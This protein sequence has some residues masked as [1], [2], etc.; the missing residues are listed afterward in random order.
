MNLLMLC[1]FGAVRDYLYPMVALGRELTRA[2]HSLTF[3]HCDKAL[4]TGCTAM[5]ALGVPDDAQLREKED[6]CRKCTEASRAV[7]SLEAW[8]TRWLTA[9]KE[10]KKNLSFGINAFLQR[11]SAYELL[12][13][14][15]SEHPP[16]FG[17][18]SQMW[19]KRHR[20]LVS[21]WPQAKKIIKEKSFDAVICYNSLYGVHR[22]FWKAAQIHK[23]PFFSLHHSTNAGT[24]DEFFLVRDEAFMFL[25]ELQKNFHRLPSASRED[26]KAIHIHDQA[27]HDS[28]KLWSYS[29]AKAQTP[30]QQPKG[31][32][33]KKVLVCLSSQDEVFAAQFIGVFPKA[34]G[35]HAFRDQIKWVRW[36]RDLAKR[37]PRV[38]FWIRPHPRLYPNKREG[39]L[40]ELAVHL[41]REKKAGGPANFFWPESDE[42]GS[43][44]SH[45]GNTDVLFNAWSSLA[46]DFGKNGTPVL[47]FFPEYSNSGRKVDLSAS[48]TSGY[49]KIFNKVI[50]SPEDFSNAEAHKKWRAHLLCANTFQL[51]QNRDPLTRLYSKFV[52]AHEKP[53]WDIRGL[54]KRPNRMHREVS[55]IEKILMRVPRAHKKKH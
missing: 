4:R 38:L 26:E 35:K 30:S 42:Q 47:T 40:S 44:W 25:R 37:H 54:F 49:E 12:L 51:L 31:N 43:V 16:R 10:T 1:P 18:I 6:I 46:D 5:N 52:P 53:K 48:T 2:G 15:K 13:Q 24:Q 3:V 21:L 9:E 41:D 50:Q 28:R 22:M 7:A 8:E 23:I 55:K 32:Y 36:V 34:A 27:M 39:Q 14:A 45:L 11:S 19:K 33:D 17:R 29:S 20:A